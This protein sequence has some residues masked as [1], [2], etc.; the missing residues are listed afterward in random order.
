MILAFDP[1]LTGAFALIGDGT[2]LV[3]DLPVHQAQHGKTAKTRAELDLHGLRRELDNRLIQHVFMERVAAR[4]GQGVTS[5]FRFGE[6]CGALYGLMVGLGLPV[7]FV[8]PQ[9]WQKHHHIGASPDAARQRAVQLYPDMGAL[10]SRKKDEHRADA[11]LLAEYGRHTL[12]GQRE[13]A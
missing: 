9:Q 4:P 2:L 8:T 1:G 12:S 7:T 11:L 6:A 3:D 10:L 5:M 13:A